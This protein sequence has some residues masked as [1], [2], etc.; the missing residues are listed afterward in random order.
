MLKWNRWTT[1]L[2]WLPIIHVNASKGPNETLLILIL[3]HLY[4]LSFAIDLTGC[5]SFLFLSA[6]FFLV[7][8]LFV[9]YCVF[10]HRSATRTSICGCFF[11]HTINPFFNRLAFMF[12]SK[13]Q[14]ILRLVSLMHSKTKQKTVLS[15]KISLKKMLWILTML[16]RYALMAWIQGELLNVSTCWIYGPLIFYYANGLILT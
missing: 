13:F 9:V 8:F 1:R 4:L 7:F 10:L 12:F 6:I 3:F 2:L 15:T 11:L 5:F 16:Q 14:S